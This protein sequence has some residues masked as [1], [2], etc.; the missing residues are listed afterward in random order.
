MLLPNLIPR[1]HS[2]ACFYLP[3]AFTMIHG[4]GRPVKKRGRPGSIYHMSGREVD[5]RREGPIFKYVR[6]KLESEFLTGQ[7]E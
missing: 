6:T 4:N 7:D 3:F 1:P 2:Q 5:V